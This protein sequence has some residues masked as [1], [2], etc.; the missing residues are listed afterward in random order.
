MCDQALLLSI[1]HKQNLENFVYQYFFESIIAEQNETARTETFL[2]T[3][4]MFAEKDR[5]SFVK[6]FKDRNSIEKDIERDKKLAEIAGSGEVVRD[7]KI[8]SKILNIVDEHMINLANN[9]AH[10]LQFLLTTRI[11]EES[12][13]QHTEIDIL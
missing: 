6:A 4:D 13:H 1:P 11:K 3:N 7:F 9:I 2:N 5:S 10:I 12:E 8:K